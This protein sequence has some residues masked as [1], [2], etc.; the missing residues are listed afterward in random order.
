METLYDLSQNTMGLLIDRVLR[1]CRSIFT[2]GLQNDLSFTRIARALNHY[3]VPYRIKAVQL[4]IDGKI[5]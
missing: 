1:F 3:V 2:A 4:I 5:E